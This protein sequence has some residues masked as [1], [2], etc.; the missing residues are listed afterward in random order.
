MSYKIIYVLLLSLFIIGCK[1]DKEQISSDD[2]SKNKVAEI[3]YQKQYD[4]INGDDKGKQ[5]GALRKSKKALG[6]STKKLT[7]TLDNIK[8]DKIEFCQYKLE[9]CI[10]SYTTLSSNIDIYKDDIGGFVIDRSKPKLPNRI[11]L[12]VLEDDEEFIEIDFL[13][14][15]TFKYIKLSNLLKKSKKQCLMEYKNKCL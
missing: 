12:K 9:D 13:D 7:R 1:N 10:S 4:E 6:R 14:N 11:A 2:G 5:N 8:K 15:Y 3:S